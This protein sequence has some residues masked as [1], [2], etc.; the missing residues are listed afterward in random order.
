MSTDIEPDI[1]NMPSDFRN[2]VVSLVTDICD[3][4]Q[5][6]FVK[7]LNALLYYGYIVS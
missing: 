7:C 1:E 4:Y 2:P 6:V 3:V 5:I